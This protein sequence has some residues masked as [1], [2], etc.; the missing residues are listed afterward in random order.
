MIFFLFQIQNRQ[1]FLLFYL[2]RVLILQ[3]FSESINHKSFIEKVFNDNNS[4]KKI[5]LKK[6]PFIE[7][8]GMYYF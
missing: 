1:G 4:F 6:I 7:H 8:A 3:V 5:I 2:W